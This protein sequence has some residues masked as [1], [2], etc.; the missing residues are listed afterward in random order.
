MGK[1]ELFVGETRRA[2]PLGEIS[3]G[4]SGSR[5][6]LSALLPLTCN[7]TEAAGVEAD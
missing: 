1:K 5:G 4:T 2:A 7:M 6:S 3:P